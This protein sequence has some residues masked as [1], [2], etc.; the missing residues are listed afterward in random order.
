[1]SRIRTSVLGATAAVVAVLAMA[2]PAVAHDELLESNPYAGEELA[3]APEGVSLSFSAEVLTMG[4]AIIV[5]D[6]DGDDW[7][8]DDPAVAEGTVTATLDVGMPDAGY[9]IRWRVV[10]SDGH[11]ISGIIPF[12]VGDGKPLVR[13]QQAAGDVSSDAT[14]Q[15]QSTQDNGA[16]LRVVLIGAGGAA[17]AV[18]LY[19]G[20]SFL[21]RRASADGAD[22]SDGTSSSRSETS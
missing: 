22:A 14:T 6:Q 19:S 11:P 3:S 21:R 2:T 4:A 18:A 5:V 20:I 17:L 16:V 12:T 7:V 9:E 1:M 10:S 8:V 15:S 13:T